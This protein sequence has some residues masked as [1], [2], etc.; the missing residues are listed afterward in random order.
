ML[1]LLI[2]FIVL[3]GLIWLT[4]WISKTFVFAKPEVD[5]GFLGA[6]IGAAGTI[7]AGYMVLMATNEQIRLA[8]D[9][10][11]QAEQAQAKA[12][13][14]Q[15]KFAKLQA[16]RELH[17]LKDLVLW[18]DNLLEPF[19]SLP[20]D[21]VSHLNALT[22]VQRRGKLVSFSGNLPQEFSGVSQTAWQRIFQVNNAV[23]TWQGHFPD[24][25][26]RGAGDRKEYNASVR[27]VVE[28]IRG[29]RDAAKAEIDRREKIQN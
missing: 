22:E 11:A 12:E 25:S 29:Y 9:A 3:V 8:K 21:D 2:L 24:P 1:S 18:Y 14:N 15:A 10:A 6:L 19:Q 23:V 16:E 26:T 28:E 13:Q 17:G 4:T 7:F 27:A 5:P 20:D